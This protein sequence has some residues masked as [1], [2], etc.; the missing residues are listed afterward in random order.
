[1]TTTRTMKAPKDANALWLWM[2]RHDLDNATL[3]KKIGISP[4]YVSDLKR[5]VFRPSDEIKLKIE[6]VTKAHEQSAGSKKPRGVLA[7]SWLP[8]VTLAKKSKPRSRA[9]AG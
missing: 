1:M 4:N 7:S 8:P 6:M 9:A 2:E 5:G 3:A